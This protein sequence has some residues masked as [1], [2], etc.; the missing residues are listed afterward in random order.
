L[1]AKHCERCDRE[2][3]LGSAKYR[4]YLEIT[5]DWDGYLPETEATDDETLSDVMQKAAELDEAALEDQVHLEVTLLLCPQCRKDLL[6]HLDAGTARVTS[7][8][9]PTTRVQ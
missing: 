5:S 2:L 6:N 3:P 4:V 9:K 1:F 8:Q 7:K